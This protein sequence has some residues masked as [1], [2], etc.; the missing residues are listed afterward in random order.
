MIRTCDV[1]QRPRHG[2]VALPWTPPVTSARVPRGPVLI[3]AHVSRAARVGGPVLAAYRAAGAAGADYVELPV[4]GTADGE[5][6]AFPDPRT[7]QG[8]LV[9]EVGYAKLCD[10][11]GYAVPRVA[12][13]L[14]VL[15]GRARGH[16]DL[17]EV[18][19]ERQ[20]VELALAV[21]GPGEFIVTSLED[22]SVA[23]IR[24]RF[25][26]T[27]AVPAALSLGRALP[28]AP[29]REWRQTRASE[30]WPGSRLRACGAD[31]AAVH[32]RLALAGTA[33]RCRRQHRRVMVW[34]VSGE[35]EIR[36]WLRQPIDVLV[37]D[38][39]ALAVALRESAAKRATEG[40]CTVSAAGSR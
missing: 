36:Y 2:G 9:C 37:T 5:L 4:R 34:A 27:A 33:S 7:I 12:D 23:A 10:L 1:G 16:L 30:L 21:L 15:S 17:R 3:S 13:V 28:G 20:L 38:R 8:E 25:P 18:G 29:R 11:A 6:V 19:G 14:A 31:W 35:R 39:P 24:A 26:D 22:A 32:H 40:S